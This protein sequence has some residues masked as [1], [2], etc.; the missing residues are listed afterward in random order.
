MLEKE[1]E[2]AVQ[3]TSVPAGIETRPQPTAS[4]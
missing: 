1:T 3:K 4:D 2:L